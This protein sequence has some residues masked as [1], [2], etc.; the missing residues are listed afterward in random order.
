[1]QFSDLKKGRQK[2]ESIYLSRGPKWALWDWRG[3]LLFLYK[4]WPVY[5]PWLNALSLK[6]LTAWDTNTIVCSLNWVVHLKYKRTQGDPNTVSF[7]DTNLQ[8]RRKITIKDL[9]FQLKLKTTHQRIY[10][11]TNKRK[12]H[13][14]Q[15]LAPTKL[16]KWFPKVT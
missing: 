10:S 12:N 11:P 6:L 13:N 8:P 2:K 7:I 14:P 16:I 15:K 1:M 4:Q 3:S 9:F 5:V